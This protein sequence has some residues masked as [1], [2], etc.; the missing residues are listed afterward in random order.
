MPSRRRLPPAVP[1]W[2]MPGAFADFDFRNLRAFGAP[3][4]WRSP[5]TINPGLSA[6][7]NGNGIS[8]CYLPGADGVFRLCAANSIKIA[9][10]VG[11]A[12]FDN[13]VY[14]ALQNRDLTNAAWTKTGCTAARSNGCDN[15]ANSGSRLTA[16][17][18]NAT[19]SQS[20]TL[21][22]T[23]LLLS[24]V[25]RVQSGVGTIAISADGGATTKTLNLTSSFQQLAGAVPAAITNPQVVITIVTSG[26]VIDIDFV[27]LEGGGN[28]C[29][30]VPSPPV[31]VTTASV[32]RFREI[33]EINNGRGGGGYANGA[34]GD[35][36]L[37]AINS[38]QAAMYVEFMGNP[39]TATG[40]PATTDAIQLFGPSLIGSGLQVIGG[41]ITSNAVLAGWNRAMS[42]FASSPT[43][44]GGGTILRG[45]LNAGPLV[46]TTGTAGNSTTTH[47]VLGGNGSGANAL[48]GYI[49]RVA[50]FDRLPPD[51]LFIERTRLT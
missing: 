1:A 18:A 51:W 39:A 38:G 33:P 26:D 24:L 20:I 3:V 7:Q 21:A 30:V 35:R 29:P 45:C 10:G 4:S 22:S 44:G 37:N 46:S 17:T 15:A 5:G 25:A 23:T 31:V 12:C 42:G 28:A 11:L 36:W 13:S 48:N 8:A 2:V 27:D 6:V 43:A 16:T 14:Y 41:Q 32:T 9:D 47:M 50:L 19:C 49:G 40:S 34:L